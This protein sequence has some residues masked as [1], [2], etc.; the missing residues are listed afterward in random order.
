[1][2]REMFEPYDL[3]Q[4]SKMLHQDPLYDHR[5]VIT[6]AWETVRGIHRL[7]FELTFDVCS[8]WW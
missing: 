3:L 5:N 8:E 4:E 1:M 7:T 6:D 2:N